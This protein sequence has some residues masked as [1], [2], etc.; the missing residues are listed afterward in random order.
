[1]GTLKKILAN[2]PLRVRAYGIAVLVLGY[3]LAKGVLSAEDVDFYVGLVGLV[4]GV[5][6]A[7]AAVTPNDKVHTTKEQAYGPQAGA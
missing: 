6:T 2:E 1:M 7:R 5:E 3:L 4:L